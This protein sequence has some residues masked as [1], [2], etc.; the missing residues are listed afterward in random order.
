MI[1]S[2]LFQIHTCLKTRWQ[3]ASGLLKLTGLVVMKIRAYIS[4]SDPSTT[5]LAIMNMAAMHGCAERNMNNTC[6]AFFRTIIRTSLLSLKIAPQ[7]WLR[8][9]ILGKRLEGCILQSQIARWLVPVFDCI[10]LYCTSIVLYFVALYCILLMTLLQ[11]FVLYHFHVTNSST[12]FGWPL[13]STQMRLGPFFLGRHLGART[14]GFKL[15]GANSLVPNTKSARFLVVKHRQWKSESI[16]STIENIGGTDGLLCKTWKDGEGMKLWY[17]I[18]RFLAYSC[19]VC[20]HTSS[21]LFV[22]L[23]RILFA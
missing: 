22:E 17:E 21:F 4:V 1:W 3:K 9:N 20:F 6:Q 10:V 14:P 2:S 23:F 15:K 18:H 16:F 13:R 8:Y 19:V 7:M 11:L 5:C 12:P